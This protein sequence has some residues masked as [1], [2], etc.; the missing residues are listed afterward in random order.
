MI[1]GIT[2]ANGIAVDDDGRVWA[3]DFEQGRARAFD[4]NGTPFVVL[5]EPGVGR[6][7]LRHPTDVVVSADRVYVADF[8]NDR[9]QV[10]RIENGASARRSKL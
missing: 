7:Q 6:E 1:T 5:G 2:V 10:W 8:G 3:L 9:V 4:P